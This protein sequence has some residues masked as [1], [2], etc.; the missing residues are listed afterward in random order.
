MASRLIATLVLLAAAT[1]AAH[2]ADVIL[3]APQ[4]EGEL[5]LVAATMTGQ[6]LAQLAPVD[7]DGDGLL[8]QADADAAATAIRLGFW[9][10]S[11]LRAPAGACVLAST[12]ARVRESDVLLEGRYRCA[13]GELRQDFKILSV[14]P[15]NYQVTLASTRQSVRWP[16]TTLTLRAGPEQNDV[17]PPPPVWVW[18]AFLLAPLALMLFNRPRPWPKSP[19][20]N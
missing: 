16:A 7:A 2:D 5:F 1:A 10:Q 19:T 12:Q 18:A 20:T 4:Q 8:S 11:P 14:L 17:T 15:K 6:T 13:E 3:I 9:D